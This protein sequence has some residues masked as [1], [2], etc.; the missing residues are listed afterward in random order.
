MGAE[1]ACR[2]RGGDGAAAAGR[3]T[4][5]AGARRLLAAKLEQRPEKEVSHPS[6]CKTLAI[7]ASSSAGPKRSGFGTSRLLFT[8]RVLPASPRRRSIA[9][10]RCG[11][12]LRGEPA[13]AKSE[14]A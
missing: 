13:A 2:A 1:T 11:A 10:I 7:Q 3:S 14:A 9:P 6:V 5:D 12:P 8:S 4:T